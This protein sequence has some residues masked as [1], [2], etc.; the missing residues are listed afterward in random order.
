VFGE[1]PHADA[2]DVADDVRWELAR[3]GSIGIRRVVAVDLTRSEFGIPVVRVVIPGLEGDCRNPEYVPGRRVQ[4]LQPAGRRLWRWQR[5]PRALRNA[6]P[7]STSSPDGLVVPIGRERRE[8]FAVIFAGPS[9][10][11][12]ARPDDPRLVWRPPAQQGDVYRAA[13][14]RPSAIGLIDG[15]FD[16]VPSVWHKEILWAME[17]GIRVYGAASIGAL[18]AAELADFGMIGVGRIFE[19]YRDGTLLDDDEVALLHGP[20]QAGYVPLT[21]PMVNVRATIHQA[22]SAGILGLHEAP[23]VATAAK[24]QHYQTRRLPIVLADGNV[25]AAAS[26]KLGG[27]QAVYRIDQKREDACLMLTA[28][29][30]GL[31]EDLRDYVGIHV[32]SGKQKHEHGRREDAH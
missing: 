18:R 21:E 8:A 6:P 30:A 23:L 26:W 24:A 28:V 19:L 4:L 9:L 1:V 16:A 7:A 25:G 29:S 3:L 11:P 31:D 32:L 27:W 2:T 20:E 14:E 5:R 12:S 10:P 15:Y 22:V 13:L 17:Q